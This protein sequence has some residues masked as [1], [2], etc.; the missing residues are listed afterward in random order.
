M[1]ITIGIVIFFVICTI[2]IFSFVNLEKIKVNEN[3]FIES[4]NTDTIT[5]D[6]YTAFSNTI[7]LQNGS[8]ILAENILDNLRSLNNLDGDDRGYTAIQTYIDNFYKKE[9]EEDNKN[10]IPPP[11]KIN[12]YNTEG[13]T[14]PVGTVLNN[15][16]TSLVNIPI[17]IADL[18]STASIYY[19]FIS[20]LKNIGTNTS[21]QNAVASHTTKPNVFVT[22][23][24]KTGMNYQDI[25]L[26]GISS[27][28][29]TRGYTV[30]CWFYLPSSPDWNTNP[31]AANDNNND[32]LIFQWNPCNASWNRSGAAIYLRSNGE[33][34]IINGTYTPNN[35]W[36]QVV[37]T[38]SNAKKIT[39]Y[40]NNE[41][42]GDA[43]NVHALDL[44]KMFINKYDY[45]WPSHSLNPTPFR[46]FCIF[47]REFTSD[48]VSEL[49]NEQQYM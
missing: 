1:E 14:Q 19:P 5:P 18:T 46:L 42:R 28:G 4:F 24:G 7:A 9:E 30:S 26:E 43:L 38:A 16:N 10:V 21:F 11:M 29:V 49:Y 41:K 45:Q 48:Q 33:F 8:G 13:F 44:N 2:L 27:I 3:S 25:T 20:D 34:N 36:Q 15:I 17:K 31:L 35:T 40:L 6:L 32:H 39:Y 37:I 47:N 22:H 23:A 12:Y